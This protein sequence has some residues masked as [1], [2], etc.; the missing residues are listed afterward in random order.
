[1]QLIQNLINA[2]T[3]ILIRKVALT[4]VVCKSTFVRATFSYLEDFPSFTSTVFSVHSP[5]FS[6]T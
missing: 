4:S 5:L 6:G 3:L 2:S 1:M